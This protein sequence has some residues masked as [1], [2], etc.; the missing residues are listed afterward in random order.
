M[1]TRY[2]TEQAYLSNISKFAIW[3]R[4][5]ILDSDR[6][7]STILE[8]QKNPLFE[9]ASVF[10]ENIKN[11]YSRNNILSKHI[12][13]LYIRALLD[14]YP[15]IT[16]T[17]KSVPFTD[18]ECNIMNSLILRSVILDDNNDNIKAIIKFVGK[19]D[20]NFSRGLTL[21]LAVSLDKYENARILLDNGALVGC[22]SHLALILAFNTHNFKINNINIKT[23]TIQDCRFI[24][25]LISKG[26]DPNYYYWHVLGN[27][28]QRMITA[29]ES[30]NKSIE[31]KYIARAYDYKII[32]NKQRRLSIFQ[33]IQLS[34]LDH[35]LYGHPVPYMYELV[36]QLY[37]DLLGMP[38]RFSYYEDAV[39]VDHTL[40][41]WKITN[42]PEP[43]LSPHD[44][45]VD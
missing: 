43:Y 33:F 1:S 8:K 22:R 34:I 4:D 10:L 24:K 2:S 35:V 16:R 30:S 21:L 39:S 26:S 27:D 41:Y 17:S 25:L 5:I 9:E 29:F 28:A 20:I 11:K 37:N 19:Y 12:A 36:V 31:P 6:V 23:W 3:I 45:E 42:V 18:E 7:I 13:D 15:E 40:Q 44:L 14:L 38:P 32:D